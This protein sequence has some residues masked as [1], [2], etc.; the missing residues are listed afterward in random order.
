MSKRTMNQQ[1]LIEVASQLFIERGY[2]NTSMNDIAQACDIKKPSLYHH[3]TSREALLMHVVDA[4]QKAF[5]EN[6]LSKA[7]DKALT[8]TARLQ[9][10]CDALTEFFQVRQWT[11][12]MAKLVSELSN[13]VPPFTEQAQAFFGQWIQTLEPLL[14]TNKSIEQARQLAQESVMQ[15]QGALLLKQVAAGEQTF[16]RTIDKLRAQA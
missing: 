15:M 6:V 16:M 5:N 1:R 4:Y 12:L 2:H 11:C 10:V 7:R 14:A 9:S 8:Q 13:S 3:V